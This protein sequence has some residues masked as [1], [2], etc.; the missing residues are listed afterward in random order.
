MRQLP[1]EG[2]SEIVALYTGLDVLLTLT[3]ICVVDEEGR[4]VFEVKVASDPDA[5]AGALPEVAGEFVRV[6]L[7]AGPLSQW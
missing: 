1:I 5:I 7:E 4:M 6:G 3:S 2:G